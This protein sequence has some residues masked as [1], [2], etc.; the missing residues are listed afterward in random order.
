[1]EDSPQRHLEAA[2]RHEEAAR[3]HERTAAF[4]A[5]SGDDERAALQRE[6]A[7]H[8]CRGAELEGR[9]AALVESRS[10]AAD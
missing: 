3:L 4:W 6:L 2:D 8:E 9:R 1:M 10:A 5:Q 7:E